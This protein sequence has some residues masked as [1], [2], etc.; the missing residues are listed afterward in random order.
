VTVTGSEGVRLREIDGRRSSQE[1]GKAV[2]AAAARAADPALAREITSERTWRKHYLDPLRLLVEI[3]ARSSR[4]AVD[5]ARAGLSKL[6]ERVELARDGQ[7]MPFPEAT[8]MSV[9]PVLG[10]ETVKGEGRGD[11]E[12][13]IPYKGELLAGDA[14]RRRLDA[15]VEDGIIEPSCRERVEKVIANPDWLDLSDRRFVILGGASEMGAMEALSSWGADIAAIDLPD[16]PVWERILEQARTGRGRL[17]IPVRPI[18]RGELTERAGADLLVH[19]PEIGD[20]LR[21]VEPPFTII[22]DTYADGAKFMLLAASTDALMSHLA[23]RPGVS[24]AYLA[25]PTDVF[26]VSEQIALGARERRRAGR[27][28]M[29]AV[30]AGALYRPSYRELIEGEG[31]RRW[32]IVDCLVPQQGANYAL[33][34]TIQRWRAVA[35]RDQGVM[36]SANVAPATRTRSVVKN[37]ALAAAFRGASAFGIEIFEPETSRWLMAALLVHDLRN[38]G[39]G[40]PPGGHPFDLFVDG[41]AHGGIWRLGYE[42]RSVLPLA[43]M[44]GLLR[45]R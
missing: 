14:L 27:G 35:A 38:D 16:R 18:G 36:V 31:G 10:T 41:A 17:Q 33:A 39:G 20:W 5:I 40:A 24:L 13:V 3:G 28:P 30:S 11:R 7:T 45:R 1:T 19:L 34:K 26:A 21:R 4:A 15:W 43:V 22:D 8:Q 23:D 12:L 29:R 42:P 2:F 9:D 44:R 37:K 25:T 32:G 6:H